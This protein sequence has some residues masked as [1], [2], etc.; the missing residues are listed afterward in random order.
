MS[1]WTLANHANGSSAVERPSVETSPREERG[2]STFE[3]HRE[4]PTGARGGVEDHVAGM[5][6]RNDVEGVDLTDPTPRLVVRRG[7]VLHVEPFDL[8]SH[9][10]LQPRT[11]IHAY[12]QWRETG[13]RAGPL[14][15]NQLVAR[16]VK[17]VV[18]ANLICARRIACG[19]ARS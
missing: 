7:G 1:A 15:R 13:T 2:A 3:G 14:A 9:H 16:D 18:A 4:E 10:L 17:A 8:A 6:R 5:Q 11:A 19:S 12:R